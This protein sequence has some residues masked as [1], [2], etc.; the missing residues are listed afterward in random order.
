MALR[1]SLSGSSRTICSGVLSWPFGIQSPPV[2]PSISS[3]EQRGAK[4]TEALRSAGIAPLRRYYRPLRLLP[5]PG[6]FSVVPW[7][8]DRRSC[9]SVA[10]RPRSEAGLPSCAHVLSRG[11]GKAVRAVPTTP[12]QPHAVCACCTAC[13]VSLRPMRKDSACGFNHIEAPM[14]SLVLRPAGS[15]PPRLAWLAA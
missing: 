1:C 10:S 15:P 2:L 5:R 7:R 11:D 9:G 3:V 4:A 13:G 6:P 14:G 12:P 8:S